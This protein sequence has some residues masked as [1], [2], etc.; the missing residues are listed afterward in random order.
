M[1]TRTSMTLTIVLL[2]F[3][4][5]TI[6]AQNNFNRKL[7]RYAAMTISESDQIDDERKTILK[8]IGDFLLKETRE[9][10]KAD[11]IFICTQNSRRSQI[12]QVWLQ[13]AMTYYG[14]NGAQVFSGG[15]EGTAFH[16]NAVTAL[17]RAGFNATGVRSGDNLV[18]TL[19]NG[20]A[21]DIMYSKKYTDRQNPQKDFVAIMVCS[22]ADKSCPIVKG[23]DARFSFPYD[24][25][26]YYDDTPSQDIKYDETVRLIAR[27]MFYLANYVKT[28]NNLKLEANK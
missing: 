3:S 14:I 7:K 28:Q 5:E 23:A 17:E 21:S 8:E 25:P 13:T 15:L 24:D 19:S 10:G 11:I 18:Y 1:K 6:I 9:D 20:T 2:L 26:R 16:P 22:D 12:A 4:I 27:E